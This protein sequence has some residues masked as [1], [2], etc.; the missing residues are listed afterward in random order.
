LNYLLDTNVCIAVMNETSPQIEIRLLKELRANSLLSVSSISVFEL[1]YGIA[2]SARRQSN[3]QK[4]AS[5]LAGRVHILFFDDED[6]RIAGELRAEIDVIGRPIDQ[7]DLLI[8]GQALRHKMTLVTANVREFTRVK[9][10]SW[11]DWS[12]P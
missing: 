11:E 1:W 2:K 10:L 8:A 7:Y 6:A 4:L 9:T 5:F 12:K 3:T